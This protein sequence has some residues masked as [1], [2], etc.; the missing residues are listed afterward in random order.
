MYVYVAGETSKPDPKVAA[1]FLV[2]LS[3]S[4]FFEG[5][6]PFIPNT[7]A[8]WAHVVEL[9]FEQ[10]L[11]WRLAWLQKCDAMVILPGESPFLDREVAMAMELNIPVY[12]AINEVPSEGRTRCRL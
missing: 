6:T 12:F 1:E 3:E 11:Q 2:A 5:H 8:F 7:H 10:Q 4:L 9:S